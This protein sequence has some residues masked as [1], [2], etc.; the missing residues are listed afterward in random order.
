M[1]R[2]RGGSG[3]EEAGCSRFPA[4]GH[5][6]STSVVLNHTKWSTISRQFEI[7]LRQV[8]PSCVTD[9]QSCYY[10]KPFANNVL[11][12]LLLHWC[13]Q[14]HRS[15]S[16]ITNRWYFTRWTLYVCRKIFVFPSFHLAHVV[17]TCCADRW[18]V[19]YLSFF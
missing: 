1:V 19:S 9:V 11:Q 8:S 17:H 2:P 6:A 18:A 15:A 10:L 12:M 14:C 5:G 4:L 3:Q 7:F 16:N 13:F